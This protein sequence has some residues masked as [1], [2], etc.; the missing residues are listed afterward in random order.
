MVAADGK[1]APSTVALDLPWHRE[2]STRKTVIHAGRMWDGTGPNVRT[3]IDLTI[4]GRRIQKIEPHREDTHQGADDVVDASNLTVM[5]GLWESH[6]HRYGGLRSYGDRSGRIWLAYGFTDL[7]SQG[8]P[9][10]AQMEAKESF[11]AGARV[12]PRYFAGGEPIDGERAYYAS[13]HGVTDEKELQLEL[14]RAQALEYDNLKT[15]VRL[16][17]ELGEKA[18]KFAHEKLGVWAASHYGMPGL[19]F[20]M[21]GMTHVSATSRWGYSYT[22]SF[23][24]VSYQDIRQ[25]FTASGEFLIST[26]FSASALYAE[27]PKIVEDPRIANLNTPWGVHDINV[28]EVRRASGAER[29]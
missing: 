22:R 3:G 10:Y 9:A 26:P 11:G 25:L 2:T 15:Y 20:G 12:G 29:I 14:D 8:D 7:Q 13:D 1:T 4:V 28:R 6:N 16:S 18:V 24:G 19:A 5:P 17:H 27:D 21:D 23:G